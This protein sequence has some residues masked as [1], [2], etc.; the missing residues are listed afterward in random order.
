VVEIVFQ[1]LFVERNA[2]EAEK[3][4]LEI[5]QIP[6]NG[7]AI[8]AGARI[9]HLVIQIAARFDLKA[10][11]Q[12]H[13]L[14]ISFDHLRSDVLTGAVFREKLKKSRVP[15]VFF[16]ISAV[17]QVFLIYF[18]HRQAVPAKMPGEFQESDVLLVHSIQDANGAE[19]GAGQPDDISP[20]AAKLALKRLHS[21]DTRVKMLL[22]KLRENVH[23]YAFHRTPRYH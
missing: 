21:I 9:T 10:R 6:G 14:A 17:G 11:Q 12:G 4:V 15:Q 2:G 18:R 5:I 13:H 8:E 20:R 7:L 23:Q 22:E 16:E 1:G 3:V 19:V